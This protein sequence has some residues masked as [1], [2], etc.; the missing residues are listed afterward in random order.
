MTRMQAP[1]TP[2]YHCGQPLGAA[3]LKLELGTVEA[4]VC[5]AG[6]R[7]AAEFISRLGLGDFYEF[8]TQ[9]SPRPETTT[10]WTAFDDPVL[11]ESHTRAAG[12]GPE[13]IALLSIDGMT[14]AACSWLITRCLQQM[15]G[16]GRVSVNT[17]T[18]RASVEWNQTLTPLSGI[19]GT[20]A[21]LGY[22][23]QLNVEDA[24]GGRYIEE[25]RELLKRLAVGGL[26]MMQVMMFAVAMYAGE[27]QGMETDVR[28]YLR[29]VSMLVATPVMLYGGWPYLR[30]AA[31]AL[32]RRTMTMDVPVALG[33][34]LAYSASVIDTARH[35]GPVYFDS[36]T[37]FIFF[38]TVARYVEMTARHRSTEVSDSL[39]RMLPATAQRIDGD[40]I[41]EIAAAQ[42]TVGDRLLV[43]VG[44]SVPADG[45]ITDG[46]TLIDEAM[47]SGESAPVERGVGAKLTGGTLNLGAPVQMRVTA[48]GPGTVLAGIVALLTRAQTERPRVARQGDRSAGRFLA[49][50]LIGA[51]LV[52]GVWIIVDP[53]RAFE[54]TLAVLVAACPCAFSLASLV[55]VAS[56]NAALAR[57][58]VL[59]TGAD[60][61]EGLAKV[62]RVIFDKTG[63][64]TTGRVS[65]NRCTVLG[66][67]SEPDCLAVAT[68]LEA[69]SEHPIAR[70]FKSLAQATSV[71][72]PQM[73]S[74][75]VSAGGGVEGSCDGRRYRIG[76]RAFA[77]AG[78]APGPAAGPATREDD[79]AIFLTCDGVALAAFELSDAPRPESAGVVDAIRRDGL[80]VEI[81]SGDSAAAVR[82]L[83]AACGIESFASRQSPEG[84][85]DRVRELTAQGE[86]IAMVGDG[87]N[88]APVLGGAGVSIAMSRGSALTLASADL[89]LIGDSLKEL[90]AALA[91][92]R[93][94][95][96]IMRQNLAWAAA[97]NI[98]AMPLAALGWVPPWAAAIGMSMSSILVVLNS[99]RLMRDRKAGHPSRRDA[100]PPP[101]RMAGALAQV[102][103][104]QAP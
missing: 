40:A 9:S 52:C 36:V 96:R 91:T 77:S 59:V 54:A 13:R 101:Q 39:C 30:G 20:I 46:T 1:D 83:A 104:G 26:G 56:A 61:I 102:L 84:K 87:I 42:V 67:E 44:D 78:T 10:L 45:L 69:G 57:R 29:I 71:P 37:M 68:A 17:A 58:G 92:A 81:S 82:R 74:I 8:R 79:D 65:I 4:T 23:P 86:F 2:C 6:C 22:R 15:P 3:P 11:L 51:A 41:R 16:V 90:P 94:A 21:G 31:Q 48:T 28:A 85:L 25:R 99:L 55:A 38:L 75:R 62:T 24:R 50:V 43:R 12:T 97:Y 35:A 88:D 60:A 80:A 89:I 33:L 70:A 63:T 5:C 47:L 100:V 49:R 53:S 72:R 18:G 95:N 19:L 32:G 103:K 34:L 64:L 76:T 93:R 7:A 98:T 27:A 14:C 73:H 66:G